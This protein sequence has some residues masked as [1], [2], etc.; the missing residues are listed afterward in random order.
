MNYLN[1]INH[2]PVF[3]LNNNHSV[4]YLPLYDSFLK[5]KNDEHVLNDIKNAT[6][7]LD[8]YNKYVGSS[9]RNIVLNITNK[10]NLACSYC[11]ANSSPN[12][13]LFME[14]KTATSIVQ[15]SFKIIK[16]TEFILWVVNPLKIFLLYIWF[17]NLLKIIL[18]KIRFII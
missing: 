8:V 10:C 9:A 17:I 11:W 18:K 15:A 2:I 4:M 3:K 6:S 12:S 1:D 13:S 16:S 7:N 14:P 5:F